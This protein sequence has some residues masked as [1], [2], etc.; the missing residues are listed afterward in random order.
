[1]SSIDL[2]WVGA[3]LVSARTPN[4]NNV[5]IAHTAQHNPEREMYTSSYQHVLQRSQLYTALSCVS[6]ELRWEHNLFG[7][8]PVLPIAE[9]PP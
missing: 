1:M 6:W 8:R 5:A 3:F 9:V 2:Y 4:E 7:A